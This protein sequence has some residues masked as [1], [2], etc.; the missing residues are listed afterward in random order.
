MK[1]FKMKEDW[2]GVYFTKEDARLWGMK[3]PYPYEPSPAGNIDLERA[4]LRAAI[5]QAI[6]ALEN[7]KDTLE[8]RIEMALNIL[9]EKI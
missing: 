4:D 8:L 3:W 1:N 9:H 6:H 2:D 5:Q 7:E